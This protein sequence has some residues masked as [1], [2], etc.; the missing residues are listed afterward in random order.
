MP[1]DSVQEELPLFFNKGVEGADHFYPA[2]EPVSVGEAFPANARLPMLFQHLKIRSVDFKNRIWVAPMC[3]Y[4]SENGHATDFHLVHIGAMALRG[5]GAITMECTAVRPEGRMSPQDAGLWQDSQIEPLRRITNFVHAHG[6]KIGVQLSHAGRKASTYA[7]WVQRK[8]DRISSLVQKD[9]ATEAEG[10]WPDEVIGPCD[11]KYDV[12][13]AQPHPMSKEKID[14]VIESFA[15]AAER[16]KKAGYDYIEIHGAHGYLIHSFCSPLS[17]NR[18]DEYGG[19]LENR[20]R[21]PIA[22]AKRVREAWGDDKPI[23]WRLSSTDWAEGPEQDPTTGE[24]LQWGIEQ[25]TVL[26]R[27]LHKVAGIDLIDVSS[28]GN[29]KDAKIKVYPGY[30]K[31]GAAHIRKEVPEVLVAAVGQITSAVQ[32]EGYLEEGSADVIFFARQIL[33]NIDFPLRAAQELLIAVKPMSQYEYGWMG[34]LGWGY[35]W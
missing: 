28:G 30:Q 2:N 11:I 33:R 23:F 14:E 31:P 5:A 10:G 22:L 18:T 35:P 9:M 6:A 19:S 17:N 12:G 3:M 24:W 26:S 13:Y 21:M 29:W 34:M 25:C 27:E 32:A 15:A 8:R 20:L 4:S 1:G 16:A 7:P